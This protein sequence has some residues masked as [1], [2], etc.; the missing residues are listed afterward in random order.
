MSLTAGG[1]LG[2]RAADH[3]LSHS[4]GTIVSVGVSAGVG[5]ADFLRC[6]LRAGRARYAH[7]TTWRRY[8]RDAHRIL[9]R[10]IRWRVFWASCLR[11]CRTVSTS[12]KLHRIQDGIGQALVHLNVVGAEAEHERSTGLAAG[13][14]TGPLLR[15]LL[16]LRHDLVMIGRTALQ[17]AAR[18]HQ[19]AAR[20]VPGTCRRSLHHLL[21]R[22][23]SRAA[24]RSAAAAA[25]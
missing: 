3:P 22:N 1:A 6:R 12:M 4:R 10:L 17:A 21:A 11:A 18:S 25:R 24:A 14:D 9:K 7:A 16:R 23:R 20:T 2:T 15:T 19:H 8:K 5:C 13:P